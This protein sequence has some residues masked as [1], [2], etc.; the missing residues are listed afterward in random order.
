MDLSA[1][2]TRD[3]FSAGRVA[4]PTPFLTTGTISV[5]NHQWILARGAASKL[6]EVVTVQEYHHPKTI[7]RIMLQK[8]VSAI[9]IP[10]AKDAAGVF[11]ISQEHCV[12][13]LEQG[14]WFV[15]EDVN[16]V[17]IRA[18]LNIPDYDDITT[19]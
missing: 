17:E 9:F 1:R 10:G 8:D 4:F 7:V 3:L 5:A 19:R 15:D 16:E 13:D 11:Q 2:Q 6:R 14:V 12:R 18:R